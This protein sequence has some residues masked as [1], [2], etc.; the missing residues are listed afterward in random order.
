MWRSQLAAVLF[1]ILVS[2]WILD[3]VKVRV[4]SCAVA[5]SVEKEQMLTRPVCLDCSS[6]LMLASFRRWRL[7]DS[8]FATT[9]GLAYQPYAK[10][11]SVVCTL[12]VVCIYDHLVSTV[13][14]PK[15]SGFFS[16]CALF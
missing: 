3:S 7:Q 2:F 12:F 6:M 5:R 1:T 13:S 11:V 14:K 15:A 4:N 8:V 10:I 9:V 16:A